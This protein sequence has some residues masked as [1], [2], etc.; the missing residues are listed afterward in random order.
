MDELPTVALDEVQSSAS[1][2]ANSERP[3]IRSVVLDDRMV[4]QIAVD[5]GED[6]HNVTVGDYLSCKWECPSGYIVQNHGQLATGPPCDAMQYV[7]TKILGRTV[8]RS[9]A[10]EFNE[11]IPEE[12]IICKEEP[13][14]SSTLGLREQR[15]LLCKDPGCLQ[16]THQHCAL[17]W[18]EKSELP[19]KCPRC[20]RKDPF[21]VDLQAV[22][23]TEDIP[24]GDHLSEHLIDVMMTKDDGSSGPPHKKARNTV[25]AAGSLGEWT[26]Q[27]W[28]NAA[29]SAGPMDKDHQML[30]IGSLDSHR[31]V[32]AIAVHR[33]SGMDVVIARIQTASKDVLE[34]DVL[35]FAGLHVKYSLDQDGTLK[36]IGAASSGEHNGAVGECQQ[37]VNEYIN[38]N[39]LKRLVRSVGDSAHY[40]GTTSAAPDVMVY[41]R[42]GNLRQQPRFI[43]E[44]EWKNRN[45]SGIRSTGRG[46]FNDRR[47]SK[48]DATTIANSGLYVRAFLGMKFRR[49]NGQD[50]AA[51]VLWIRDQ[52]TNAITVSQAWSFGKTEI[53]PTAL[54][55]WA[56]PESADTHLPA[57]ALQQWTRCN[58]PAAFPEGPEGPWTNDPVVTIDANDLLYRMPDA[59]GNPI[60]LP[61]VGLQLLLREIYRESYEPQDDVED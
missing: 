45:E 30:D 37:Q 19:L 11:Q 14:S 17:A 7:S 49:D 34:H 60:T 31:V 33:M 48:S 38:T 18:L 16:P 42:H 26:E 4:Y 3:I 20:Q 41:S 21:L 55:R 6:R 57:V 8:T 10:D 28:E 35:R 24:D 22:K 12:C 51:A 56:A 9:E 5:I 36:V 46:Y 29:R 53:I 43:V 32:A 27:D 52:A 58:P 23:E 44:I 47:R 25:F 59:N 13:S 2:Q 61:Q 1:S 40:L 15:F 50:S 54:T 39:V